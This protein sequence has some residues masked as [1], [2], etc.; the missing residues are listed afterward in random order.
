LARNLIVKSQVTLSRHERDPCKDAQND[1]WGGS[2]VSAPYE[3]AVSAARVITSGNYLGMCPA[4]RGDTLIASFVLVLL[5]AGW[6][7]NFVGPKELTEGVG[8]FIAYSF[9]RQV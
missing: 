1:K 3:R 9:P 6:L 5:L 8:N 4:K 7:M 2:V